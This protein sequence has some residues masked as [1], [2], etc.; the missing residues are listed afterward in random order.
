[1]TRSHVGGAL[2][3]VLLA[4]LGVY[5]ARNTYWVDVPIPTP[6]KGEAVTNPFYAAQRFA[7]ALG[8]ATRRAHSP[9]VPS[10][11]SV[12]VLSAWHWD[13]SPERRTAIKRWVESG[14]RLVVDHLLSG[15]VEE[16]ESWSGVEWDFNEAAANAYY[17]SHDDGSPR[18]EC[19]PVKEVV[20]QSGTSYSVCG[21][22]FSF[23]KTSRPMQ[24]AL[25]D[26][27][28]LQAVR[29]G[30]GEGSVT[31]INVVPF[32]RRSLFDGDHATLFVAATRL[33]RGDE[34]LFLTEDDH[35]SLLALLWIYGAPSVALS[36]VLLAFF[37]WR[38]AARFGPMLALPEPRRRSM[39]EQ[40]RGSGSFALK[41]GEG[42][43][44][45]AA[46]VRA[47]TEAA[48][49]RI[50][51]YSQLSPPQRATALGEATGM[52]G[53]AIVSAISVVGK[54]RAKE[55]PNTL[56]LLEC[57]RRQLLNPGA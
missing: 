28:G 11:R 5:V 25:R 15:D 29:V 43:P 40:I 42:A 7:E 21:L 20:P 31:V 33:Q 35:P 6:P 32:T 30:V 16:F 8:A 19:S 44:L 34:V 46:A 26:E 47:L 24:W 52:D 17:E 50:P 1:M 14:G 27:M 9:A 18:P 38:G 10:P 53:D 56:A 48:R 54:R 51:A 45:H 39:A 2:C 12:I 36:L 13:L 23:L 55:L 57:A 4:A 37:L 22:Y 41:F 49:R 3:V